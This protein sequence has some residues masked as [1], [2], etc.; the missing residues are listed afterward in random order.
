[1]ELMRIGEIPLI[2]QLISPYSGIN[3]RDAYATHR[4]S[5]TGVDP[6]KPIR[7]AVA[8]FQLHAILGVIL[9]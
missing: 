6:A 3:N 5:P 7:D 2:K 8:V 9:M 4:V 1:M